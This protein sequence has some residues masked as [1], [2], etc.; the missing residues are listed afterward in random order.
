MVFGPSHLSSPRDS[1]LQRLRTHMLSW[2]SVDSN[3]NLAS[4]S[5]VTG[6][7]YSGKEQFEQR[8]G[9]LSTLSRGDDMWCFGPGRGR[10]RR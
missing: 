3:P 10:E 5:V 9:G 7:S 6:V 2:G 8:K 4:T 1:L